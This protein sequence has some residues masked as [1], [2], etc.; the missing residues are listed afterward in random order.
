MGFPI[1]LERF[2]ELLPSLCSRETASDYTLWTPKSPLWGHCVVVSLA[3]QR[4][5]GGELLVSNL[6]CF[7]QLP[8]GTIIDMVRHQESTVL[9]DQASLIHRERF[10]GRPAI[11][12]RYRRFVVTL[13]RTLEPSDRRR[14]SEIIRHF[15]Q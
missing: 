10:L 9:M 14:R 8:D 12:R 5:C 4:I 13:A 3:L 2:R 1:T 11:R 15:L 6:H 7:N